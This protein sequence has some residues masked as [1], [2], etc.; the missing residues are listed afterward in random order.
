[1]E[2]AKEKM[3]KAAEAT[4]EKVDAFKLQEK[5]AATKEKV[6]HIKVNDHQESRLIIFRSKLD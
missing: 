3:N 6:G 5:L 1:M 2:N 4:K